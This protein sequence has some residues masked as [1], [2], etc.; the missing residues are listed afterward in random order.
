VPNVAV[1]SVEGLPLVALPPRVRLS[2]FSRVLKQALDVTASLV[3]LFLFSPLLLVVAVL[4]KRDSPGPLFFRQFRVGE[5]GEIFRMLKFRTMVEDAEVRKTEFVH[6]NK[7]AGTD[8]RMFKIPSDPRVTRI[9]AFLRQYSIDELP[10][11][12]NVVLGQM[13]LVGP[14]PL[15]P[16]EDRFVGSWARRRLDLKPGITGPWQVHGRSQIPFEEMVTL[17]YLYVTHW[18]LR[19][20]L[21]LLLRTIAV[22]LRGDATEVS[23]PSFVPTESN[24]AHTSR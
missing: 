20:D 8:P 11:L 7:H 19:G 5:N 17:D 6:L 21:V 16:A 3:A 24:R 22:V 13:S 14:R 9:G 18:S 1:H 2:G 4:I 10:Q 23:P 12:I 15:I